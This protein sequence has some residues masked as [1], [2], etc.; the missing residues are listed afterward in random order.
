[1]PIQRQRERMEETEVQSIEPQDQ[2]IAEGPGGPDAGIDS[3]IEALLRHAEALTEVITSNTLGP[4]EDYLES[5]A[6]QGPVEA[7]PRPPVVERPP[8]VI[9]GR[10]APLA[11]AVNDLETADQEVEEVHQELPEPPEASTDDESTSALID[12]DS[13]VEAALVPAGQA[14]TDSPTD[15]QTAEI[16]AILRDAG[17]SSMI[18]SQ[19]DDAPRDMADLLNDPDSATSLDAGAT[20][21]EA[22]AEPSVEVLYI[23]DEDIA[24][25]P[26]EAESPPAEPDMEAAPP[27]VEAPA[28]PPV[29]VL[30]EAPVEVEAAPEER[31]P[32]A[33]DEPT[34]TF[35]PRVFALLGKAVAA[36]RSTLRFVMGLPAVVIAAIGY[37]LAI[38]NRPFSRTSN[39]TR[40][41]IGIIGIAT[42]ICGILS[43]VLP[44]LLTSNPFAHIPTGIVTKH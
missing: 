30:A 22:P 4:L 10:S 29:E 19:T 6:D 31:P 40:D 37:A 2:P 11:E 9:P 39:R 26:P 24:E 21:A 17:N 12:E 16:D 34:S 14:D 44:W 33:T 18:A 23:P 35:M 3:D 15:E 13:A 27:E 7:K 20:G 28:P 36:S 32:A 5:I 1:M 25:D 43:W 8:P 38:V 42:M 41:I